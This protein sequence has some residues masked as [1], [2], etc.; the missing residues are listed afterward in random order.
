LSIVGYDFLTYPRGHAREERG[1]RLPTA[2]EALAEDGAEVAHLSE[3]IAVYVELRARIAD[4]AHDPA[5]DVAVLPH[6]VEAVAGDVEMTPA[7]QKAARGSGGRAR[8]PAIGSPM[9][10]EADASSEASARGIRREGR[11]VDQ[12]HVRLEAR[13]ST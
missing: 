11:P 1:G 5:P 13:K 10:T 3:E 6:E 8:K 9:S 7:S 2:A 12:L 4:E